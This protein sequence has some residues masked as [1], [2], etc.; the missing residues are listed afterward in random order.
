[1]SQKRRVSISNTAKDND[2]IVSHGVALSSQSEGT[3]T[4]DSSAEKGRSV[5]RRSPLSSQSNDPERL[6]DHTTLLRSIN[7]PQ[8]RHL[9]VP[10]TQH[11]VPIASRPTIASSMPYENTSGIENP[12]NCNADFETLQSY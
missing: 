7:Q 10:R 5:L 4:D 11:N 12:D 8:T 1:M 3:S 2:N 6:V 9:D